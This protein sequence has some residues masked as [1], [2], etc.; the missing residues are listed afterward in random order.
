MSISLR[1]RPTLLFH[2]QHALRFLSD[3]PPGCDFISSYSLHS[4]IPF[5]THAS[6]RCPSTSDGN[7][8]KVLRPRPRPVKQQQE[9]NR[10]NS[11]VATRMFVIK[12]YKIV[13]KLKV[14]TSNVWHCFCTY[15]TKERRCLLYF[16][17]IMSHSVLS[18]HTVLEARPKV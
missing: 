6:A 13:Q 15:R 14:M 5:L 7:K 16:S 17:I 3:C 2:F 12:K 8:T 10:K 1:S 18:A 9:H 4:S 11:S